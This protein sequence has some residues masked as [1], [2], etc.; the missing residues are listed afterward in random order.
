MPKPEADNK[1]SPA[2]ALK[3]A[4]LSSL[5]L[6]LLKGIG[7]YFSGSLLV[8]ASLMDSIADAF[9]SFINLK[10]SNLA[11]TDADKEHPFGHGG[12]EVAAS[13]VQ[14]FIIVLFGL[15][16]IFEAMRRLI[17]VNSSIVH[18]DE[19]KIAISILVFSALGGYFIQSFLS[20]QIL[21]TNI[22]RERSLALEADHAHYFGDV[23]SNFLSAA[24]L[25]FAVFTRQPVFDTVF[26]LL[27]GA[28]LLKTAYPILKKCYHDIVHREIDAELQ[29]MIVDIVLSTDKRIKG[30]HQLRSRELGPNLFVD[31]H[32]TLPGEI[33]LSEAH[34]VGDKVEEKIIKKIPRADIIIHLDPDIE[35]EHNDWEVSYDLNLK[36]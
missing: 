3:G 23:L 30:I 9:T 25:A 17:Y 24:G 1:S 18:L 32:M 28:A 27:A 7:F 14:G 6:A 19:A 5:F 4:I 34:A 26:A 10:V 15:N 35:P 8:L 22:K 2:K 11:K 12:F 29:Q 13:L 33:S 31:F 36:T 20:R 21:S 16:I